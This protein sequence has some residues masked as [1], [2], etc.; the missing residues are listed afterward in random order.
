MIFVCSVLCL[1]CR[2]TY[3]TEREVCRE[4]RQKKKAHRVWCRGGAWRGIHPL[5]MRK[6]MHARI[7]YNRK[8]VG[9]KK[10]KKKKDSNVFTGS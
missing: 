1:T 5:G 9:Q 10:G 8:Q 6:R 3:T 7:K 2:D 4:K